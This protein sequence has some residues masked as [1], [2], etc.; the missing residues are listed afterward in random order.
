MYSLNFS[1]LRKC[2]YKQGH[3]MLVEVEGMRSEKKSNTIINAA[4][5]YASILM[6][7]WVIKKLD[8]TIIFKKKLDENM[9]GYCHFKEI[10]KGIKY[11]EIE[12]KRSTSMDDNLITLAHEMVHLKQYAMGE[13]KDSASKS[14]CIWQKK[15]V[16]E[17]K[18]DYWDLPWEI[19]AFGREKGLYYRFCE[20]FNY[21]ILF[22]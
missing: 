10:D 8:L 11:F 21:N 14:G 12:L 7:K 1:K 20:K 18:T 9:E 3:L 13:L 19:E 4:E 15:S 5:F 22:T 6:P 17:K 2:I 16:N